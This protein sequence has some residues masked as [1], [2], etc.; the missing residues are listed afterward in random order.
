[1][2]RGEQAYFVTLDLSYDHRGGERERKGVY[3]KAKEDKTMPFISVSFRFIFFEVRSL[4]GVESSSGE[5]EE[6]HKQV[7][8]LLQKKSCIARCIFYGELR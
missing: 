6:P 4:G 5:E 2:E 8:A 1:M 7:G 3:N